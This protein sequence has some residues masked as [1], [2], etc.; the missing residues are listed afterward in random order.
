MRMNRLGS[1]LT[2]TIATGTYAT[3][4]FYTSFKKSLWTKL[5]V[6]YNYLNQNF[7]NVDPEMLPLQSSA[8]DECPPPGPS[9]RR[10][11]VELTN[12]RQVRK[13]HTYSRSLPLHGRDS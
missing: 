13:S 7:R 4:T 1:Q 10:H 11:Y 6:E 12:R 3:I 8:R 2:S 5:T 9:V